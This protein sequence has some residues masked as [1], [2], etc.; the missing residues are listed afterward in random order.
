M[1]IIVN[2]SCDN[3]SNMHKMLMFLNITRYLQDSEHSVDV[4]FIVGN[5]YDKSL[6]QVC[7]VL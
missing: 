4:K 2:Y 5:F 3:V 6:K 7:K 1:A